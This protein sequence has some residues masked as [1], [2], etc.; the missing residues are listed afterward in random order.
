M[1]IRMTDL[2]IG[3]VL[4]TCA[5]L[6]FF[7]TYTIPS[8]DKFLYGESI[9]ASASFFPR[10]VLVILAVFSVFLI[11]KS[12]FSS[13][14]E[15]IIWAENAIRRVSITYLLFLLF[16]LFLPIIGNY[17][18]SPGIGFV[19]ASGILLICTMI[20]L[21]FRKY[22]WVFLTSVIVVG[23]VYLFFVLFLNIMLP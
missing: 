15:K 17:F 2:V 19:I 13:S 12:V 4:L 8:H 20:G 11:I 14:S 7:Y 16:P 23:S 3:T 10:V 1:R 22:H 21:G 5:I 18:V 9:Y 6:G